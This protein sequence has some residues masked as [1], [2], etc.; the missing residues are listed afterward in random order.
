[1]ERQRYDDLAYLLRALCILD[2]REDL[3][4]VSDDACVLHEAVDVRLG[5]VGD[6]QWV[7]IIKCRHES[8]CL[9]EDGQ[10]GEAGLKA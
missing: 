7:K 9:L 5:V 4:A 6:L 2:C 3:C 8:G 1:M 10:E